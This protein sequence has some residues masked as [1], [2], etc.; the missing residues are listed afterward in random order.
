MLKHS[1]ADELIAAIRAAAEGKPVVN[2]Q[3]ILTP[4][5]EA[6]ALTPRQ[7]EIVQL[8]V[9]GLTAKEIASVLGLSVRTIEFH[10]YRAMETLG[11]TSSAE[12]IRVAL[13]KGIANS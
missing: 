11:V 5:G 10:K 9:K 13:E 4:A 2:S 6:G 1:A 7:R 3:K 12:L 8:V